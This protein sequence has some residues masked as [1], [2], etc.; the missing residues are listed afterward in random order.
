MPNQIDAVESHVDQIWDNLRI[1]RLPLH[2]ALFIALSTFEYYISTPLKKPVEITHLRQALG[3]LVPKLFTHCHTTPIKGRDITGLRESNLT[4][5]YAMEAMNYAQRYSW[6]A[7]HLTGYRQGWFHCQVEERIIRFSFTSDSNPG[8]SLMHHRLKQYHENRIKDINSIEEIHRELLPED[9]MRSLESA[10]RHLSLE[11][12]LYSIPREVSESYRKFVIALSPTATVEKDTAFSGYTVQEYYDFWVNLSALMLAYLQSCEVKYGR[13]AKRLMNSR[14]LAAEPFKIAD[15]ISKLG[16]I[17]LDS[18]KQIVKELVLDIGSR[19]PDIQLQPMIPTNA[20]DLIL[21]APHLV[22][23]SNWEICLLR[24]W[25]KLSP[26][27]YGQVV[28]AKKVKL[29]DE[30]AS[31]VSQP[32]VK[33]AINRRVVNS[34]GDVIGDVD[35]AFFDITDGYLAL[36]QLK[37]L[38]EPDSFQEE[39]NAREELSK[40]IEQIR[41]CISLFTTERERLIENLFPQAN[42]DPQNVTDVQ[43][44]LICRGGIDSGID[45]RQFSID[46]LDYEMSFD[47]LKEN[48]GL[49]IR[50]RFRKLGDLHRY[51]LEDIKAKMCYNSIKIAGYL[52]QTPGLSTA[53]EGIHYIGRSTELYHPKNFCFCGSGKQYRDCCKIIET[54]DESDYTY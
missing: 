40:G 35:L 20:K 12:L 49:S 41:K 14:V 4:Y 28:A 48:P 53:G 16:G 42:I 39:S 50:E 43:F 32:N 46:V 8:Q 10:L 24:S 5:I 51:I 25:A 37:W 29:A 9:I 30:L 44:M 23:T 26:S 33:Q 17:S 47:F 1:Y 2:L 18:S 36:I 11:K 7:Y 22:F 34:E 13:S 21:L 54:L 45:A 38:I 52:C 15:A 19:R 27:K 31:L 3:L 6:I